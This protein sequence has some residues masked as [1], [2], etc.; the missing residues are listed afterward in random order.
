[1]VKVLL[2][3]ICGMFLGVIIFLTVYMLLSLM[4]DSEQSV[5]D[6]FGG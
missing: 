4:Y 3:I 1:M 2:W 6:K 5:M